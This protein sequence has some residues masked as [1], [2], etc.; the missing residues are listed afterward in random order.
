MA[1]G[2]VAR[3]PRRMSGASPPCGGG[4]GAVDREGRRSS[5]APRSSAFFWV[6]LVLKFKT[7]L[8]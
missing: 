7:Y 2:S 5:L 8:I 4:G 3:F 6:G 1:S